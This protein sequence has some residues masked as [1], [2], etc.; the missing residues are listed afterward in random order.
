[1]YRKAQLRL[2]LLAA[3]LLGCAASILSGM[4]TA[5]SLGTA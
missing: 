2:I 5:M 4:L 3:I 1:M